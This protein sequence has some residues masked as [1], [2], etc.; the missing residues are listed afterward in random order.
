[1]REIKFRDY[2]YKPYRDSYEM[3]KGAEIKDGRLSISL[4]CLNDEDYESGV[5]I[6]TIETMQYTGLKDKNGKEIYEGD[7]VERLS[8]QRYTANN[9]DIADKWVSI[10]YEVKYE[11]Q[12]FIPSRLNE[13]RVIG[14]IYENP[15][16]LKSNQ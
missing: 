16:L 13:C 12:T 11:N 1:M 7:I 10:N 5:G 8:L 3:V 15:E 6:R 9:G 4:S 2:I 14:N